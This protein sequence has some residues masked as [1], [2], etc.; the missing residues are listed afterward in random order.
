LERIFYD[1]DNRVDG[2]LKMD[3]FYNM[4]TFLKLRIN[5]KDLKL[6]FDEIDF[7]K[8]GYITFKEFQNFFD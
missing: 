1:F 4:L 7:E 6:L 2:S 3:E 5:K 8:K